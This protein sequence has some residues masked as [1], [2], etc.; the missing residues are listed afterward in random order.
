MLQRRIGGD[1]IGGERCFCGEGSSASK[2]G[3]FSPFRSFVRRCSFTIRSLWT[4]IPPDRHPI[5]FVRSDF[6]RKPALETSKNS[7]VRPEQNLQGNPSL[8]LPAIPT[9]KLLPSTFAPTHPTC[10]K[11]S[12]KPQRN[13][14]PEQHKDIAVGTDTATG[15]TPAQKS[16]V[17]GAAELLRCCKPQLCSRA[18]VPTQACGQTR[19]MG[20]YRKLSYGRSSLFTRRPPTRQLFGTARSA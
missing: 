14:P 16:R 7:A 18:L 6:R 12:R 15:T 2:P 11:P 20:C 13:C 3:I 17:P 1:G 9:A 5:R 19:A 10:T 8:L 4:P